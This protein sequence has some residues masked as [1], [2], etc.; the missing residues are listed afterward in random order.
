MKSCR[1]E[2]QKE[3][4]Q[5]DSKRDNNRKRARTTERERNE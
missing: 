2:I 1:N 5:K 4:T 3:E